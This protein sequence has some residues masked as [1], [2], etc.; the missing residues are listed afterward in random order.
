MYTS[1][2]STL[3]ISGHHRGASQT[4]SRHHP[5]ECLYAGLLEF[6]NGTPDLSEQ[7]AAGGDGGELKEEEE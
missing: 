3:N 1:G 5:A 2:S 6:H 7:M 4:H